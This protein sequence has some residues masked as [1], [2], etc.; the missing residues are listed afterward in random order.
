MV[1]INPYVMEHKPC[2]QT[3]S[4][5]LRKMIDSAAEMSYKTARLFGITVNK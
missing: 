5:C 2:Q 4:D 3:K 1:F